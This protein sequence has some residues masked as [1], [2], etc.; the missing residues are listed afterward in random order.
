M[1][2]D[3]ST[4]WTIALALAVV[5][6]FIWKG[7]AMWRAGRLDQPVWFVALLVINTVGIL[8]I[9]YLLLSRR[10]RPGAVREG[11]V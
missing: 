6:E 11:A 7:A 2:Y 10:V 5:W 1:T 8:P 9:A 4:T 3:L